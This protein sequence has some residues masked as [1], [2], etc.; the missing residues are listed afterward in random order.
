MHAR[1]RAALRGLTFALCAAGAGTALAQAKETRIVVG[2]QPGG[3]TDIVARLLAPRFA[4]ALGE[5]VLVENKSGAS[6]N[7]AAEA[8]AK[9]AP[10]GKTLLLVFNSHATVGALFPKLSFD[11]VKDFAAVGLISRSPYLV[12]AKPDIGVDNLKQAIDRAKKSK[13]PLFMGSP[14]RATPQHLMM[15][16]LR[17]EEGVDI[18]VAHFKGTAPAL[19]DVMGSHVDFTLVTT[20][21]AAGFAKAG[22][23][24]LLAV[25]SNQRLPEFPDVPTA[26]ELGIKSVANSG[27][28]LAL[29]VPAKTPRAT[30]DK[31]NRILN[32]SLRA[33]EVAEKL[34]GIGMTPVGG[35]PADL[36][37]LMGEE[38]R[39][40]AT[41]IKELNITPE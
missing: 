36:D 23:L 10:D 15:E 12:A 27:V 16:R 38:N 30:V 20:S 32:Q 8:V 40:W 17:K 9:A 29:M 37:K 5:P 39:I 41:L 6:G 19:T 13:K 26:G 14:G 33:P 3:A 4:Q 35:T 34:A 18:E 25:T 7:I 24:K 22:K 31:L 11:P 2:N 28:W 1:L 21:A